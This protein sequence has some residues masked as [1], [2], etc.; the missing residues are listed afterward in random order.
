MSL[1][2]V[3]QL[4]KLHACPFCPINVHCNNYSYLL[5]VDNIVCE[6]IATFTSHWCNVRR[7]NRA[8]EARYSFQILAPRLRVLFLLLLLAQPHNCNK[9][10]VNKSKLLKPLIYRTFLLLLLR[11]QVYVDAK[12]GTGLQTPEESLQRRFPILLGFIGFYDL[13]LLR[14][15]PV[16]QL[17]FERLPRRFPNLHI[18]G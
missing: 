18:W 1:P 12:P 10:S 4:E 2:S 13:V 7:S 6:L 3:A 9:F 5:Y 11:R 8:N 15:L 14:Q 16:V 17:Q